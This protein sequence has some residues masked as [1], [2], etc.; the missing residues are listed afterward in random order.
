M[1][2]KQAVKLRAVIE[3]EMRI[4]CAKKVRN[5]TEEKEKK[6]FLWTRS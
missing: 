1:N 3:I 4:R 2:I 6:R 5:K